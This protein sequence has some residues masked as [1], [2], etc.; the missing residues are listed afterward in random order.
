MEKTIAVA[1]GTHIFIIPV[2]DVL[3]MKD[4]GDGTTTIAYAHTITVNQS[5]DFIRE[6]ME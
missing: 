1:N 2:S 6:Q 5:I 3:E 4:N